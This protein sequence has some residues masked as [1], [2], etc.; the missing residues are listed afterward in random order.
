MTG[1]YIDQLI[2]AELCS[3]ARNVTS[4]VT[5]GGT[6]PDFETRLPQYFADNNIAANTVRFTPQDAQTTGIGAQPLIQLINAHGVGNS[7]H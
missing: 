7:E 2:L 5:T 6:K 1:K 3:S 4:R